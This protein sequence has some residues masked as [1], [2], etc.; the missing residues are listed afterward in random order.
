[1]FKTAL[2]LILRNWWR[3][4]TFMLISIISLT[5][6]I[7][8][9]ALLMSFVSYENGI[10]K[11]NPNLNKIVWV[12]QNTQ[13]NSGNN[14]AYMRN[15][16]AEQVKQNYPEVEEL[17]QIS[18]PWI[19]YVEINNQ[20]FDE[21]LML[22][23]D[24]SFSSFFPH[25]M[26]YGSWKALEDP[27]AIIITEEQANRFFG[28]ENAI[29]KQIGVKFN[30]SQVY[31][32][33]TF[34]TIGGVVK[35]RHQSAIKFDG[36]FCNPAD[37]DGGATLLKV[38][39]NINLEQ[40][41]QKVRD[42]KVSVNKE[43][44][45]FY[46]FQDAITSNYLGGN[47]WYSRKNTLLL[48][49]LISAVLVFII[50]IFNYVNMS[51]SR[52]LQQV[53]TL[54]TEKLMG[55]KVSD[56]RLQIFLDTFLTVFI[57]FILAM[58]L[59]NDLLPVFK[60]VVNVNITSSYFYSSNF[61]PLLIFLAILLTIIPAWIMSNKI[62]KLSLT[63]YRMFFVTKKKRW[64]AAMVTMQYIIAFALIN[65]TITA[66]RQ[67]NM[68][69]GSIERYKNVIEVGDMF[70]QNS[71]V[72]FDSRLKSIPG[73]ESYAYTESG[74]LNTF[75]IVL[76]ILK[77]KGESQQSPIILMAGS[78]GLIET[79]ML[80]QISGVNW[81]N[82]SKIY[83]TSVFVNKTFTEIAEIPPHEIIGRPLRKYVEEFDSLAIIAGVVE[84][85]YIYSFEHKAIPIFIKYTDNPDLLKLI[86]I[87]TK[88]GN[89]EDVVSLLKQ[90]WSQAYPDKL[91]KYKYTYEYFIKNNS[92][93]F[94]MSRLLQ[95]Y[96]IIS[97]VLICFGLFGITFYAVNQRTKEVG[98][99]K[100]NGAKTYQIFWLIIKPILT[101][102]LI[103]FVIGAPLSWLFIEKWLQQFAYRVDVSVSSFLIAF[104]IFISI[105]ILTVIWQLWRTVKVNPTE[106]L[107]SE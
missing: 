93:I 30:F 80:D 74:I 8:F 100:I 101:W 31:E 82:A 67:V 13:P 25:E 54:H 72:D 103:G 65:A 39:S 56:V 66:N 52:I 44:Y 78:D 20:K 64:I 45:Y 12:M 60:Q 98:I 75:N 62:S 91:F 3:N 85:F 5:V 106:S 77:E 90:S 102:L 53:K 61:F 36:I 47:V 84:D 57:S 17:L 68:V 10:E 83:P 69:K 51:F 55:A 92:K 49:G 32:D 95:M 29:G 34:L 94:E 48:I 89:M 73:I 16:I 104:L 2:K 18:N 27:Q 63:D 21:F 79:L 46:P 42:D 6:G 76:D 105:T 59:M 19:N 41:E 99:R 23:A 11:N 37:K 58:L 96:S 9:T 97:I 50:A 7:A 4:K 26:L 15:D 14:W 40:F 86:Y 43:Q 107:R 1:M 87:R 81:N 70:A 71:I 38:P 88:D 28:D 35:N 33:I 24:I 22:N